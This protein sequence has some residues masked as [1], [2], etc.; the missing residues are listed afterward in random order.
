MTPFFPLLGV[1]SE[2]SPLRGEV[3]SVVSLLSPPLLVD[4][5]WGD[6]NWTCNPL[7]P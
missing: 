5:S 6:S 7:L 2:P 1:G 3:I 4:G